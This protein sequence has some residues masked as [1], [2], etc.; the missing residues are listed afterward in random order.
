[1]A[2]HDDRKEYLK[3]SLDDQGLHH[4]PMVQ[5][6]YWLQEY[7]E[8]G[9][10]DST[11]FA[12]STVS[13]NGDPDSRIVLLKEVRDEQLVFFTNYNS[14]KGR[15]LNKNPRAHALFFWSNLERQVRILGSVVQIPRD[16]S[17]RYFASRPIKS[18]WGA[19]ASQQ[20]EPIA[21]RAAMEDQLRL[22]QEVNPTQVPCPPDWGGFA[23]SVDHIEFWQ[24][25]ESRLHD[26]I[27]FK[28]EPLGEWTNQR[29]QP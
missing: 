20:S 16:E 18:Q 17:E 3:K 2:L 6:G 21:N 28:R 10:E 14:K 25:R 5:F 1:M 23:L 27:R 19:A 24:G 22:T 13:S 11:A 8:T 7:R 15:D 26:R 4:D 29:L 12:L 9:A